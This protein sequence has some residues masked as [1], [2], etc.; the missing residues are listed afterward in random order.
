MV[1]AI[2]A[3]CSLIR[4]GT[5]R[6]GYFCICS[7]MLEIETSGVLFLSSTVYVVINGG[8]Y[9]PQ[10]HEREEIEEGERDSF[11]TFCLCM[12]PCI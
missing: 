1:I 10:S 4:I 6:C 9:F 12:A 3:V 5:K 7:G 2:T 8:M 11:N